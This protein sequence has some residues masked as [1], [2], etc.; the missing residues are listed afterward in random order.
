MQGNHRP[1]RS[2]A[3]IL[4][5]A[6]LLLLTPSAFATF[7]SPLNLTNFNPDLQATGLSLNYTAA[8]GLLTITGTGVSGTF[9][10]LNSKFGVGTMD[11]SLSVTLTNN[12]SSLLAPGSLTITAA[13]NW[14]GGAAVSAGQLMLAGTIY[15]FGV[16]G[17]ASTPGSNGTFEFLLN[18]LSSDVPDELDWNLAGF[19]QV[20]GTSVNSIF[21][22]DASWLAGDVDFSGSITTDNS[23]P[24]PATLGLMLL[25]LAGVRLTRNRH[26]KLMDR[27]VPGGSS[28]A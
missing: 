27:A 25:G 22:A 13:S 19:A 1:L 9:T 23:V 10:G 6:A 7:K 20:I 2:A 18:N 4:V 12:G 21:P 11:Y 28:A 3:A 17:S 15:D 24:L 16:S 26:E 8:S 5:A 14:I